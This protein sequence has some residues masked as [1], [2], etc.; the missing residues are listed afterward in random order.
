MS[1]IKNRIDH[2]E[3]VPAS[4]KSY[5]SDR[6]NSAL[7]RMFHQRIIEK[8]E[9]CYEID[10]ESFLSLSIDELA[11]FQ[12][13][14]YYRNNIFLDCDGN[15]N[16]ANLKYMVSFRGPDGNDFINAKQIGCYIH[17]GSQQF[18]LHL[19]QY[20]LLNIIQE[21]N[22]SVALDIKSSDLLYTQLKPFAAIRKLADNSGC[23]L[24]DFLSSQRVIIPEAIL[25]GI[26]YLENGGIE[27]TP[28]LG[29]VNHGREEMADF[30]PALNAGIQKELNTKIYDKDI[31]QKTY[32]IDSEAKKIKILI[33]PSIQEA[34]EE[35]KP[36]RILDPDEAQDFIS[37]PHQYL[38][39][40]HFCLDQYSDRVVEI[41]QLK[42]KKN[43]GI[44]QGGMKFDWDKYV[45]QVD[46]GDE[47]HKI[48]EIPLRTREDVEH[49]EKALE[50][51]IEKKL[52]FV[53]FK[54][55]AF[56]RDTE[57]IERLIKG[58]K[59]TLFDGEK[60]GEYE[61]NVVENRNI[62]LKIF[63]NIDQ[64]EYR[65]NNPNLKKFQ[66]DTPVSLNVDLF[67]FQKVGLRWLQNNYLSKS[68]GNLLADDMGLGKTLQILSFV[69][70]EIEKGEIEPF[71]IIVPVALIDNWLKEL[72]KRFRP[73]L[74][75][76]TVRLHQSFIKQ[77][78]TRG[79]KIRELD[80]T[81]RQYDNIKA[82]NAKGLR[83]LQE[84]NIII[85]N[86]ETVRDYQISLGQINFRTI[87]CDEAQKIKNPSTYVTNAVK[88]LKGNFRII[89]TAT[90]VEN[91]LIDLWCLVD[92]LTPGL[93]GSLREFRNT[94]VSVGNDD[95]NSTAQSAEVLRKVIDDN[96]ILLRRTKE[97]ELSGLP[98]K[99]L[100]REKI[101]M[102]KTQF[103][104]YMR[105]IRAVVDNRKAV[106]GVLINLKAVCSHPA[107][108]TLNTH[109][110]DSVEEL[111]DISPK[112][113]WI[114]N[115]LD[116]IKERN[117]KVIIFT[118]FIKMQEIMLLCLKKHFQLSADNLFLMNG[119]TPAMRRQD[120]V[121]DFN[122]SSGFSIMILSPDVGGVGLNIV[123]ANHVF[124]YTR[125]WNPAKEAQATD[126]VYRIGQEKDVY[127]YYPIMS[128]PKESGLLDQTIEE[129]IDTLL[130]DKSDVM[131]QFLIPSNLLSVEKELQEDLLKSTQ[132]GFA[133]DVISIDDVEQIDPNQFE[134]LI[135][136]LFRKMGF[137]SKLTPQSGDNGV[138]IVVFNEDSEGASLIQ[139]KHS[140]GKTIGNDAVQEVVAG[141]SYYERKYQT[142]FPELFVA[143]NTEVSRGA[144]RLAKVNGVKIIDRRELK[145]M[146]RNQEI[147]TSE[148]ILST[149]LE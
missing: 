5:H 94:Y 22:E 145:K 74:K 89:C 60:I 148:L 68:P 6:V 62:G 126:R 78:Q 146:I 70:R 52:D 82:I 141:R 2:I 93:L 87:I 125:E 27:I 79:V 67:P 66:L 115:K 147:K 91:S 24:S 136:I 90:P 50:R 134:E 104:L 110:S 77:Y 39:S 71:L 64:D 1:I 128:F 23:G 30:T 12:A 135:A 34:L 54:G 119:K 31:T 92:F 95:L 96:Q 109:Q 144:R 83:I 142:L 131:D 21:F 29:Y 33:P 124:H 28:Q 43:V 47:V 108:C 105:Y 123:G 57:V 73:N 37:N 3:L 17:I 98:Q 118:R 36:I 127:V 56:E 49:L 10:N 99:H 59:E 40:P 116:I 138:D 100:V 61:N 16:R 58:A 81:E 42:L 11:L 65:K 18:L 112:L 25:P 35:I 55:K 86:Y 32:H 19:D 121:D 20:R 117:E 85:T 4:G 15:F 38:Q 106:L 102:G 103:E 149:T 122:D 137:I 111:I 46:T 132:I 130:Q 84:A 13:P 133:P 76:K 75:L 139:C 143:T 45:I 140:H 107:I 101:H 97:K 63:D 120:L 48:V 88:A 7:D 8:H 69:C 53:V 72:K 9:G 41:A 51:A 129:K 114:V 113:K 14:A 26:E 80:G 44:I